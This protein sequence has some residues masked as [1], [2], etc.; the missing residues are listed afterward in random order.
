MRKICT[1][2]LLLLL[3]PSVV[4]L[5]GWQY[6][7]VF[8][9][10]S[11][12]HGV[13]VTPD[14]NVWVAAYG[15]T[16]DSLGGKALRSIV[17]L[18]PDGTPASF[19]PIQTV[20]VLGVTDTLTVSSRGINIDNV[21]NILYTAFDKL[22]KIDYVTGAG[23][24]KAVPKAGASLTMPAATSTAFNGEVIIGHVGADQPIYIYVTDSS[25]QLSRCVIVTADGNDVYHAPV[26]DV[27]ILKY[28]SDFGTFGPYAI[29]DTLALINF[30]ESLCWDRKNPEILWTSSRDDF[31]PYRKNTWYAINTVTKA[32]VDSFTW[33]LGGADAAGTPRGIAF[34]LG[35][36]TAYVAGY[37]GHTI[38]MFVQIPTSV[39][40]DL[41]VLPEGFALMQNYPNQFNP[42]TEIKFS[43]EQ[44]GMTT[45]VI[46][47]LLGREIE[48]MVSENLARGAYTASFNASKLSSGTY[49]YRLTSNGVSITKKMVVLK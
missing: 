42:T 5:S 29:T 17:V 3:V 26:A 1:A 13:T 19:S 35:G 8:Y 23:M 12:P 4:A 14:G 43:I 46:Y 47:D 21:G 9:T 48:T 41:N 22:Y 30:A 49:V 40:P 6:A 7:K 44:S 24:A 16:G 10:S 15:L 11:Q 33:Q 39:R 36:D 32:L 20:T 38:Q 2:V 27:G 45:L 34:S 31:A 37:D 18:H 25:K 28:H